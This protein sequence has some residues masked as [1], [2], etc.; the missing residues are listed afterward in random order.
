MEGESATV[1]KSHS[2]DVVAAAAAMSSSSS[3]SARSLS[4]EVSDELVQALR[5]HIKLHGA[6]LLSSPPVDADHSPR[7]DFASAAVYMQRLRDLCAGGPAGLCASSRLSQHTIGS[8]DAASFE[9]HESLV[10]VIE[11][12]TLR[13]DTVA[14]LDYPQG[15]RPSTAISDFFTEARVPTRREQVRSPACRC[16]LDAS[17]TCRQPTCVRLVIDWTPRSY[18]MSTSPGRASASGK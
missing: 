1:T 18:P 8:L 5:S 9:E 4:G 2:H 14:M 16:A 17:C 11:N 15:L 12:A 10:S 13:G 6:G 7:A 3:S